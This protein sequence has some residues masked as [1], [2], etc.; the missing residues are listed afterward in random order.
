M[1]QIKIS[2][3]VPVYNEAARVG[4]VLAAV[5]NH[6]LIDEVIAINDGSTDSTQSVLEQIS[7]ID[8]ISYPANRGK[9]HAVMLALKKA[10]NDF[11]MTIDSDLV[12][13]SKD[14]LTAL[15]NPIIKG[16][17]DISMS[18]RKNSL[19]FYKIC[20]MDFV[21]GERI[22]RKSIIGDLDQLDKLF[23]FGLESF[24]NLIIAKKKLRIK[25]VYLDQVITPRKSA[26]EGF[27]AG[28]KADYY[29]V[30]HIVRYLTLFG[31]IKL[32][33]QMMRLK[34]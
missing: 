26:K 13:L 10:R 33:I 3:I 21:S 30:K 8:L 7:G 23:G 34:V 22:F 12:G 5:T 19:W 24:L 25:I 28:T 11:V 1:E 20:G 2:C 14:A 29:M 16:Q 17:A 6:E 4:K 9:S 18:L 31:A 32:F 15:I 27:W